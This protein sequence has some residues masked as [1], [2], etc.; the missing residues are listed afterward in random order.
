MIDYCI[1]LPISILEGIQNLTIPW[2]TS[3]WFWSWFCFGQEGGLDNLLRFFFSWDSD[4]LLG[5]LQALLF[6]RNKFPDSCPFLFFSYFPY[7]L[8]NFGSASCPTWQPD[9]TS[10]HN[11]TGEW[12][13]GGH[14]SWPTH[15]EPLCFCLLITR[16]C[17]GV[18]AGQCAKGLCIRH[19]KRNDLAAGSSRLQRCVPVQKGAR[20]EPPMA[21]SQIR[22][23]SNQLDQSLLPHLPSGLVTPS[24][25]HHTGTVISIGRGMR[26]T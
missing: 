25:T 8:W 24:T 5:L 18:W 3:I 21:I 12:R 23:S 1:S 4:C 19:T 13:Q 9:C 15:Q 14:T 17:W 26:I 2:A 10:Q 22:C 6:K 20:P 16:C 11:A 7:G